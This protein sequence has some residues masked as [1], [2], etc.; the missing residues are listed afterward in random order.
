MAGEPWIDDTGAELGAQV[1]REVGH[2]ETV[3]ELARAAH[4]LRRAAAGLAVVLRIRPQFQGDPHR[5]AAFPCHEQ[6]RYR[7][8]H[9]TAHR[10]QHAIR[11]WG[12]GRT[13]AYRATECP[14]QGIGRKLGRVAL[15]DAEPAELGFDLLRAEPRSIEQRRAADQADDGT[16]SRN[17][18]ATTACVKASIHDA[19][20]RATG[21][22][23][24]RDSDEVT[25][26]SATSRTGE[27]VLGHMSAPGGLSR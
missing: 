14:V 12:Q 22:N 27:G 2:A 1:D 10:H 6:G 18:C 17:H 7:A 20:L 15:G 16:A 25:A 4:G 8:V 24:Q 21:V 13:S 5:L 3:G 26:C 11:R 23:H 19:P 9:A